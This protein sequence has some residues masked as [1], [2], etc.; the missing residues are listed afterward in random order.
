MSETVSRDFTMNR[1]AA[2]GTLCSVVMSET[3]NRHVL[4]N[5]RTVIL[6]DLHHV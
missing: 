2:D 3:A 1:Q 5:G 4:H 6:C